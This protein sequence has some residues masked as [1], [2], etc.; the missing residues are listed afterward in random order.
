MMTTPGCTRVNS[1][2]KAGRI[3]SGR[4]PAGYAMDTVPSSGA[5]TIQR[6]VNIARG[7]G[8]NRIALNNAASAAAAASSRK[9]NP[10]QRPKS[11]LLIPVL[12]KV[13]N[14]RRLS[15]QIIFPNQQRASRYKYAQKWYNS[16]QLHLPLPLTNR[17]GSFPP[18]IFP[19]DKWL[20][21]VY[22][23]FS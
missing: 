14:N 10:R 8:L 19:L 9:K 22:I 16:P 23:P 18:L 15:C 2:I 3:G 1:V 21:L 13:R 17:R 20:I 7:R 5:C 6:T 11:P 4:V 12:K